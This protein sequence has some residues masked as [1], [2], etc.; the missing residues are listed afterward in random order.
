MSW[1]LDL[2]PLLI[3]V[4]GGIW[5][6]LKGKE[7]KT[8]K[9]E[10]QVAKAN[11]VVERKARVAEKAQYEA[12]REGITIMQDTMEQAHDENSVSDLTNDTY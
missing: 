8:A 5:G 6:L 1:L 2:W 10:A 9:I 12:T 7:A 3:A 4:A 11:V